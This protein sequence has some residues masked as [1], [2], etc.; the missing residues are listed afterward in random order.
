MRMKKESIPE[1]SFSIFNQ[2][3]S[4]SHNLIIF[5]ALP[6]TLPADLCNYQVQFFLFC[7][8]SMLCTIIITKR[9]EDY[10]S[11]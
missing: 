1:S 8:D 4:L 3:I 6:L 9:Q 11:I 10:R 7:P 2:S 5:R